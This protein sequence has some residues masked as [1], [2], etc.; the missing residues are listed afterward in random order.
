L[1]YF[2]SFQLDPSPF[3]W[4]NCDLDIWEKLLNQNYDLRKRS[5][6]IRTKKFGPQMVNRNFFSLFLKLIN[7][8][9]EKHLEV[10]NTKAVNLVFLFWMIFYKNFFKFNIYQKSHFIGYFIN[11][12]WHCLRKELWKTFGQ[13]SWQIQRWIF[14]WFKRNQNTFKIMGF[15][16]NVSVLKLYSNNTYFFDIFYY[17]SFSIP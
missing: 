5:D 2:R 13:K 4:H 11:L 17:C 16:V 7:T 6:S 14:Q 1:N 9:N 10:L 8:K 3:V 15:F 12:S